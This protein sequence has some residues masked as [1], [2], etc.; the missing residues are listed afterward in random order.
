MESLLIATRQ[1]FH[2][3]R[4][5][6]E[7]LLVLEPHQFLA[8]FWPFLLLEIPRYLLTDVYVLGRYLFR[9]TPSVENSGELPGAFPR[10]SVILPVLNEA[11]TIEG[12]IRSLCEQELVRLEIIVVDDGSTDNGPDI[13]RRLAE[14]GVIRYVRL[15]SRQGKAGALNYG[16]QIATG[17]FLVFMDSDST[18][19]R[20]A[21]Y[22]LVQPF[23]DPAVGAVSGNIGVR[24]PWTNVLT[25]LQT[26]EYLCSISVGRQFR[27]DVGIL[28][29]VSGAFGAFRRQ[30][31]QRIGWHDPGPGNDSD[32]TIRVRKLGQTVAFA[33]RAVCLTKVPTTWRH[34]MK[35]R[36]RW[37]RNNIKN[38]LRKHRDTYDWR[39]RHFRLGNLVSFLDSMFYSVGLAFI[40][41]VYLV[42]IM[43]QMP[44]RMEIIFLAHYY[45]FTVMKL[46][47]LGIALVVSER[48]AA[49]SQLLW[50]IPITVLYR[51]ALRIFRIV[52]SIHELCCRASS[53]DPFAPEKVRKQMPIY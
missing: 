51:K 46:A 3:F 1:G 50:V 27:A 42:Q 32:L 11:D 14:E 34:W 36:R 49:Y 29:I 19:D 10:V 43:I 26:F 41:A 40:W 8:F 7:F 13:C 52:A 16:C 17:E 24:N 28:S 48:G 39:N 5:A 33:P 53:R 22:H 2:V 4:E 35:Q 18:L 37:D 20:L 25:R 6:L 38:R 31:I 9:R 30:T 15:Q 21:L 12:S 44:A 45:L 23:Q 47:Q